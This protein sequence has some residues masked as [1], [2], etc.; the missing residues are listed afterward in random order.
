MIIPATRLSKKK[1][2][3]KE[4]TKGVRRDGLENLCFKY[5]SED[6]WVC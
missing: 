6:D 5:P 4:K 3:E 1:E 2:K